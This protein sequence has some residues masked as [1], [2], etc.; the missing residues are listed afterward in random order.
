MPVREC[1]G[2]YPKLGDLLCEGVGRFFDWCEEVRPPGVEKLNNWY[3]GQR[4]FERRF[5]VSAEKLTPCEQGHLLDVPVFFEWWGKR[6]SA[7][8]LH[9]K[10]ALVTAL[11]ETQ[12]G[13][14]LQTWGGQTFCAK[15]T[16]LAT[17]AFTQLFPL[18]SEGSG[19]KAVPGHFLVWD[20]VDGKRPTTR[21][22]LGTWNLLYSSRR[23]VLWL[24]GSSEKDGILA[25]RHE[26]F[27]ETWRNF[28]SVFKGLPPLDEARLVTGIRHKGEKRRPYAGLLKNHTRIY[29]LTGL[30]KSGFTLTW[31][32]APKVWRK[33]KKRGP[34]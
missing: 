3:L 34:G 5:G 4:D 19:G 23:K 18:N 21:W 31:S 27:E 10:E 22:R 32:L 15:N 12:A 28:S 30:Y 1:A 24:G 20:N 11:K 6:L 16:V 33:I 17:G 9:R 13:V 2:A 7:L 8:N 26:Q 25:P 14:E 29:S